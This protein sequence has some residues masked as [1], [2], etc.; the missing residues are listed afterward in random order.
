MTYTLELEKSDSAFGGHT[1][2]RVNE[3]ILI[4][5]D[6]EFD[7]HNLMTSGESHIDVDFE[8]F[9]SIQELETFI[10]DKL[11]NLVNEPKYVEYR[12]IVINQGA[13]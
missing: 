6:D 3:T 1:T 11:P 8:Q 7:V 9:D 2:I 10:H 12:N 13:K 4:M 5:F